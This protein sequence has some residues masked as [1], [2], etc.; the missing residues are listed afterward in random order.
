MRPGCRLR[1]P[2]RS[3]R[4]WPGSRGI[5]GCR[6]CT[7][8]IARVSRSPLQWRRRSCPRCSCWSVWSRVSPGSSDGTRITASGTRTTCTSASVHAI[9]P[10]HAPEAAAL[11]LVGAA[12]VWILGRGA[13]ELARTWRYVAELRSVA[14]AGLGAGVRIVA[15]ERPFSLA[16]GLARGEI[17]VSSALVDVLSQDELEVVL[18][19]ERAHLERRDPLRRAAAATLSFPLWPSV[20]RSV[21]SELVLASEQACDEAAGLSI[22]D[23][24]RRRARHGTPRRGSRRACIGRPWIPA[25]W[26]ID[27][28]PSSP[29]TIPPA[30]VASPPSAVD[31]SARSN[32]S[33]WISRGRTRARSPSRTSAT[34]TTIKRS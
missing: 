19:H 18:A 8:D 24:R 17:W 15:S 4:R 9:T 32:S 30:P 12:F 16:T 11:L 34:A 20:R 2:R 27:A 26:P 22:L 7:R 5:D 28:G 31:R 23:A 14:R 25:A 3:R 6:E 29:S 13:R 21:L 10:F 33:V 1:R